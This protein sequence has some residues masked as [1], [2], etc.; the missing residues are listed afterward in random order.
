[1][2]QQKEAK[3]ETISKIIS[4]AELKALVGKSKDLVLVDVRTKEEVDKGRI[5]GSVNIPLDTVE[6]A[7]LLKPEEFQAKYGVA[8][9]A[10]DAPEVVF[11]CQPGR[12]GAMATDKAR[13]LGYDGDLEELC[14]FSELY[15][16]LRLLL[17]FHDH[18]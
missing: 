4:Y 3:L 16:A 10:L 13:K 17:S 7:L 11:Y 9:P 6:A 5:P 14:A 12:R 8:K 18:E 1:M 15:G 2:T